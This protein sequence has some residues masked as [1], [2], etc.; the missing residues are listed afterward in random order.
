MQRRSFL[1]HAS[2]GA[3][4]GGAVVAAP[5]L[6]QD[7][8]SVS[9][10]LASSFKPGLP[11]LY[12]AGEA[13]CRYVDEASGGRFRIRPSA[14]G[15]DGV[16]VFEAV[17][18]GAV[19]CGHGFASA[20]FAKDP[21]LCFDSAVPFGMNARQMNAWMLEA[22]GL[23][24]TRDLYQPHQIINLPLGNTG[25]QMG[26]WYRK[27]I[28][29]LADLKGVR[30]LT[31]GLAGEVLARLGV[32][33]QQVAA[34]EVAGALGKDTLDAVEAASPSDDE[35]LGLQKL[36]PYYYYPSWWEGGAQ[37]TLY[38]SAPAWDK[39]PRHYRSLVEAASRAAHASV[40][41]RY[42]ARNPAALSR[43]TAA[44]AQLRAFPRAVLDAAF[45]ASTEV[46]RALADKDPRFKA[47]HGNYM[48]FRDQLLP[49]FRVSESAYDQYLMSMAL[50][51]GRQR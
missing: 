3:A 23:K 18:G 34:D 4:A 33:P 12:G 9:W 2:L 44:G 29:T 31:A 17:A 50:A 5:A 30:M 47:I 25:V 10:R 6:A 45:E 37:A 36:A 14:Q 21:A 32:V 39:L 42:D 24:L 46:Y 43:L 16:Q 7:M 41:A 11:T 38:I 20:C 48:G 19:D 15:S 28:K 22:D 8:P 1:K 51:A 13:F 35:A 26:G 40:T 49:W 27:E